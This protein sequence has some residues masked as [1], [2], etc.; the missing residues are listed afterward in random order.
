[1]YISRITVVLLIHNNTHELEKIFI[2]FDLHENYFTGIIFARTFNIYKK[3]A[4]YSRLRNGYDDTWIAD[5]NTCLKAL[6]IARYKVKTRLIPCFIL[7]CK[8]ALHVDKGECEEFEM[9]LQHESKLHVYKELKRGVGFEEYLKHVKGRLLSCFFSF[10]QV[11]MDVL[12]SWVGM[13]KGVG[14]R[15]VLIV[16]FVRSLLRM[17]FRVCII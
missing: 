8:E 12:R 1:M 14:L 11:P 2:Q 13:L 9:V 3:K 5:V 16:G 6:Q 7:L 4:N 15:N 17:F 10:G